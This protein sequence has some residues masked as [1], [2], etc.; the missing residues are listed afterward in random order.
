MKGAN[1]WNHRAFPIQQTGVHQVATQTGNVHVE[2]AD[3]GVDFL[4][5]VVHARRKSLH[6]VIKDDLELVG[7][8]RQLFD[9]AVRVQAGDQDL[10]RLFVQIRRRDIFGPF[11]A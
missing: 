3:D 5:G 11:F 1:T 8:G 4:F 2:A 10:T 7:L 9:R 6:Q